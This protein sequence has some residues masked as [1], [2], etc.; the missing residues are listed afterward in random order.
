MSERDDKAQSC[1]TG[2]GCPICQCLWPASNIGKVVV[3]VVL[4]GVLAFLLWRNVL[5]PREEPPPPEPTE[6][7]KV[8]QEAIALYNRREFDEAA[9]AFEKVLDLKPDAALAMNYLGIMA[10]NRGDFV[11]ARGYYEQAVQV[12]PQTPQHYYNLALFYSNRMKDYAA[13]EAQLAEAVK[14]GIHIKYHML[15]ASCAIKRGLPED[16]VLRRLRNTIDAGTQQAHAL[17]TDH[18]APDGAFAG[19][20]VHAAQELDARGSDYGVARLRELARDGADPD[21]QTFAKGV[22]ERIQKTGDTN[23][24]EGE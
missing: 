20:W 2:G 10:E 12:D 6:T 4:V 23:E 14:R 21:V 8:M 18:L 7:A 24:T 3:L 19:V 17:G 22:L 5:S 13:A 16:E 15:L 9:A 1:P 11:E